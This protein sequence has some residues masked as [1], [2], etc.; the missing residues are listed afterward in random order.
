MNSEPV[1]VIGLGIHGTNELPTSSLEL[2]KQANQVWGGKRQLE[3]VQN[4]SGKKVLIDGSIQQTVHSLIQRAQHEKI[5]VLASGDPCFFGIAA[6]I[7]KVLPPEEVIILP[8]ISSLQYAFAKCA[9]PWQDAALTSAHARPLSQV[10]GLARRYAKLGILTDPLQTPAQIASQFL[11]AGITDCRAIVCENLGMEDE[12]ITESK[13][14]AITD[15]A[16]SPL[17]VLLVIQDH[18]WQPIAVVS[19]RSDEAYHHPRGLITKRDVRAMSILRLGI[20]ETDIIWDIGAGSGA[21]SIEMAELAWR[22]Q[23]YAIEKNEECL[24]C[25]RENKD[26]FCTHN[27][28]IISGEAPQIL[29]NLPVPG[30]VFIGGSA[31]KLSA[32]LDYIDEST[33][34]P[35]RVVANFTILENLMEGMQ[36]MK[37]HRYQAAFTEVQFSYGSQIGCGTRLAPINPVFILDGTLHKEE[38]K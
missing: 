8:Q 11:A 27:L 26:Q 32:I 2:I 16:F 34:L 7:L 14:S 3:Q 9:I 15:A 10:I 24:K 1:Y 28:E 20:H 18:G 19:H 25:I 13:L 38:Q 22:G 35:C 30:A 21:M 5:V 33:N 36:W 4:F 6:T 17:N 31:G 29:D 23:V 12:H 37:D